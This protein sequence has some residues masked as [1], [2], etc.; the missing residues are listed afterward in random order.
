MHNA[1]TWLHGNGADSWAG[2]STGSMSLTDN[3]PEVNAAAVSPHL[4]EG[5]SLV[6]V[7]LVR[8]V[9][10]CVYDC[11]G[12]GLAAARGCD[13]GQNQHG[14]VCVVALRV[15]GVSVWRRE[16]SLRQLQDR[17]RC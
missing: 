8:H 9:H 3:F 17:S 2:L 12:A 4:V 1:G 15:T 14:R 7:R 16:E 5:C 10:H 6:H 13:P 11:P